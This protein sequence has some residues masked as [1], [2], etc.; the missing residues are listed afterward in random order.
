MENAIS[1]WLWKRKLPKTAYCP[2]CHSK[3]RRENDRQLRKEYVWVCDECD[4]NFY[5]FEVITDEPNE[6]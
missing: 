6:R 3:L 5:H 4:E 2:Y 1:R